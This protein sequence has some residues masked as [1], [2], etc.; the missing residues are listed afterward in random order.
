M[1]NKEYDEAISQYTAALFLDPTTKQLLL[2]KRSTAYVR[3]GAWD[4]ALKD[5]NEVACF[6]LPPCPR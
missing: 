3:K 4:A 1:D 6:C 5:A 2:V